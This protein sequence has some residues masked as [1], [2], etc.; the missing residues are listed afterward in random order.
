MNLPPIDLER[1]NET[2]M[3][4]GIERVGSGDVAKAIHRHPCWVTRF[5]SGESG[6]NAPLV[7]KA[8]AAAGLA[9]VDEFEV[10][11]TVL[12]REQLNGEG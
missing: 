9:I 5:L 7:A 1:H 2:A 11:H 6:L 8:L 4:R 3:R 10:R 12:L